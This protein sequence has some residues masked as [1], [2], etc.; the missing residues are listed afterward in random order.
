M[1]LSILCALLYPCAA[2]LLWNTPLR[3]RAHPP[4][5]TFLFLLFLAALLL[6]VLLGLTADGYPQDTATF[7]AWA[8]LTHEVGLSGMYSGE[9]FLDYPPFYL[10]IL[11]LLEQ[12]RL[13]FGLSQTSAG[14]DLMMK[15]PAIL[16]DLLCA[17]LLYR[18]VKGKCDAFESVFL[19]GAYLF[20]PA[21][22]INSAV[23]GQV[24]SFCLLVVLCALFLL[25]RGN[26]LACA[27]VYAAAVLLKPQSLFFAPLLFLYLLRKKQYRRIASGI[28]GF[29]A[30]VLLLALPF[31]RNLDY[32]QL[33]E[34]YLATLKSYPYFSI[35]AYNLYALC[36]LNWK[37]IESVFPT[38]A[39]QWLLTAVPILLV[40]LYSAWIY[41]K[42]P[43]KGTVFLCAYLLSAG[44]FLLSVKMHERYLFPAILLL[45]LAYGYF[46]D[47]RLLAS[48][49]GLSVTHFLNVAYVLYLNNTFVSAFHPPMILLSAAQ[50]AIILY[51]GYVAWDLCIRGRCR[52]AGLRP[53]SLPRLHLP[54]TGRLER[55]ISRRDLLPMAAITAAFAGLVF[56]QLGSTQS[57]QTAWHPAIGESVVFQTDGRAEKLLYLPG[58][59]VDSADG[60]AFV[61]VSLR[62]ETSVDGTAW[63]ELATLTEGSVYAWGTI[64]IDTDFRYLRL[65]ACDGQTVLNEIALKAA[66]ED[67]LLSL[68]P[69]SGNT[70]ALIDEQAVVPL[71]PTWYDSTYFDEVY[72][73][74]TAYEHLYGAWPYES[75]H[76]PLGKLLISVG[77]ALF[78]MTPFGWRFSGA[79]F[80]TL[81]LPVLYL[82]LKRL[83]GRTSLASCGTVLFAFDFMHYTQSRIATIDTY[84]VFFLLLMYYFMAVFVDTDLRTA[85]MRRI[86][87]PLLLCGI[88]F[89]LGAAAKWS[90]IYGGLGLAALFFWHLARQA[91]LLPTQ[92]RPALYRRYRAIILWCCL[93]FLAIPA[94]IYLAAYFPVFTVAGHSFSEF[95]SYQ[96]GMYAYH[97]G[98]EATHPF[99]SPWYEWPV[100]VRPIWYHIT[101]A[102]DT[103]DGLV[104]SIAAFGNPV[105]WWGSIATMLLS[106]GFGALSR[107]RRVAFFWIGFLSV[108]LPWIAVTRISFIYHYYTAVPFLILSIV[109]CLSLLCRRLETAPAGG[110]L[111]KATAPIAIWL[112]PAAALL[113]FF[114]FFPVLSG[115]GTAQAYLES[116]EWF[117]TWYFC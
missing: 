90:A 22:L 48:F 109:Y 78:G 12:L 9:F 26:T 27:F 31:T 21:V 59:D 2:L 39:L 33:A 37:P 42:S 1:A 7:K 92:D 57:A 41:W 19:T 115:A 54:P 30:G 111:Q 50:T 5:R 43:K 36:G 15:L 105:V 35:N 3:R 62:I 10:Y 85:S 97:A 46:R 29:C 52:Q 18:A 14:F 51:T 112:I 72:H 70:G 61:G 68:T 82:L 107:D 110:R 25:L 87:L 11:Y 55:G 88:S 20:C 8:R 117:S 65:T 114:Q 108:Y 96:A 93:F 71:Y 106:A 86:C 98:L 77:I 13:W 73:A 100:M 95:F 66:G 23:W 83:F 99:S 102:P 63:Q 4:T 80:G 47:R 67:R 116:L 94:G 81:M 45:L 6:R 24:D 44:I 84:A 53:L 101:W 16:A 17:Y 89:G 56:F 91:R 60:T 74:R 104:R 34:Q 76:P 28:A 75:T 69:V 32:G 103:A 64:P 58:I 79:L 113:L 40:V 49:F 38:E